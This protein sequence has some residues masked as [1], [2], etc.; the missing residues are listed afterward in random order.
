LSIHV[1][2]EPKSPEGPLL[3]TLP[4]SSRHA[5]SSVSSK[6]ALV[7]AKHADYCF[8]VKDNQPTLKADIDALFDDISIPPSARNT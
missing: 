4:A 7:E 2:G 5:G 3:Q 6:L 8:T 1:A